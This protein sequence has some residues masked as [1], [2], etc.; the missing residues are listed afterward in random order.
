MISPFHE[1]FRK[2][3][4]NFHFRKRNTHT[5]PVRDLISYQSSLRAT[6]SFIIRRSIFLSFSVSLKRN[7]VILS[8][9]QLR[10]LFDNI[11]GIHSRFTI[12]SE[13]ICIF[14]KHAIRRFLYHRT[15]KQSL[16]G[17][18][19]NKMLCFKT[20]SPFFW[21]CYLSRVKRFQSVVHRNIFMKLMNLTTLYNF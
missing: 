16:L 10:N 14:I 18:F 6:I 11:F 12:H 20:I 4:R 7:F 5:S 13:S 21:K 19:C 17:F 9:L 1:L 15:N 3:I 2:I 8:I